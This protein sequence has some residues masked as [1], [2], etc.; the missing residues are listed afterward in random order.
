MTKETWGGKDLFH[1][2]DYS[3]SL[4]TA[5]ARTQ[6]KKL[7]PGTESDAYWLALHGFFS[8]LSHVT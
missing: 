1:V 2:S 8:L 6:M 4:R 5:R 3:S 7:E